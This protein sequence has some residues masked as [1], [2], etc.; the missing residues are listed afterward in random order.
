MD[1]C[2]RAKHR[3]SPAL[4][5]CLSDRIGWRKSKSW[6]RQGRVATTSREPNQC[7]GV[8]RPKGGGRLA[9][10]YAPVLEVLRLSAGLRGVVEEFRDKRI[11]V[12]CALLRVFR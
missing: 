9:F 7:V 8:D 4:Y 5:Q 3:R 10:H 2:S 1:C 11:S 12:V 6:G